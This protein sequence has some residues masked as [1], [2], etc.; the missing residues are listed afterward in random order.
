MLLQ[1]ILFIQLSFTFFIIF[2]IKTFLSNKKYLIIFL[3]TYLLISFFIVGLFIL[4]MFHINFYNPNIEYHIFVNKEKL[5]GL[6][7]VI[8]NSLNS[9]LCLWWYNPSY[10]LKP[11][12]LIF[13]FY[14]KFGITLFF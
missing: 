8:K 1:T 5:W 14:A 2:F 12:S 9:Y 13:Y 4:N 3:L 6:T 7:L 10:F 11:N